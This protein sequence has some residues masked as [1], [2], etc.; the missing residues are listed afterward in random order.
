MVNY[1]DGEYFGGATIF[2]AD[3]SVISSLPLWQEGILHCE[4]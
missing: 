2:A 1:I 3:G 4:I